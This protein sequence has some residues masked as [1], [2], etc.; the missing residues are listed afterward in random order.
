MADGELKSK[1]K[2]DG[3]QEYKKALNDAYR[4]LRVLRSELK[5]E[6][7]EL[8]RNATAQ[9]KNSKK[10]DSLK[11]QIDQQKKIV[12]TLTKAL[13]DSR[14]EYADNEEVQDK[15][16]EKLNKAREALANMENQLGSAEDSLKDLGDSMKDVGADTEQATQ[17]VVS[18]NDC[19]KSI[20]D[21]VGGV[22]NSMESIFSSTVETMT[23]MVEEM[24]SLMAQAWSAAGDWKQI[25][26]IWGGSLEDIE[27]VFMGAKLQGVDAGEITGGIQKLVTNV[28]SGNKETLAALKTLGIEEA[29]YSNHW[30]F[31]MDTMTKLTMHHGNVRFD[32]ATALFGDKKGSGMTDVVDNWNDMLD[33]YMTD[34]EGTG[35]HLY[36]D[37]I[38]ALDGVAHKI[39]ET[40]ELWNALKQNVGAKLVDILGMDTLGD[41]A[42]EILRDVAKI[43]SGQGDRKEVI[44]KLEDD[45]QKTFDDLGAALENLS[46]YMSELGT[47]L[48]QST[49]PTI[50]LIGTML[51][52][53][54]GVL[55]WVGENSDRIIAVLDKVFPALV[56]NKTLEAFTGQGIGEWLDSIFQGGLKIFEVSMLGKF[57]KGFFNGGAGS[58]ASAVSDAVNAGATGAAGGGVLGF[59]FQSIRNGAQGLLST[60]A[61]WFTQN[62]GSATGLG[63]QWAVLLDQIMHG[64]SLGRAL[65]GEGTFDE[66]L[67]DASNKA[68]EIKENAETFA[69]DWI[70]LFQTAGEAMFGDTV[71]EIEKNAET[72]ADDWNTLFQTAG[73][74]I[75]GSKKEEPQPV[76]VEEI[77]EPEEMAP[78]IFSPEQ[79]AAAQAIWD[80]W[81]AGTDTDDDWQSLLNLF[82]GDLETYNTLLSN[83]SAFMT[84]HSEEE[85]LPGDVFMLFEDFA[86][87]LEH[88]KGQSYGPKDT[89]IELKNEIAITIPVY[90]D[91]EMVTQ[92]VS[93]Q[94]AGSL[95]KILA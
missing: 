53:L 90:V 61:N 55:D 73:A 33:K 57:V 27:R 12:E 30:D 3:E 78:D 28:H 26:T 70:T 83:I 84:E 50:A 16:E 40:Q 65:T 68:E 89:P 92:T 36:D 52:K 35:L 4:T 85:D 59:L 63:G 80:K 88:F 11:K 38:E 60:G 5:A 41:D 9:D 74:A 23:A 69:D 75:F 77:E 87:A 81:R 66:V 13:E 43:W 8:G 48:S 15:W 10:V 71:K 19:L 21:V 42:L 79:I 32:L 47:D 46:G 1:L 67:T 31:F 34:V 45:L 56:A 76:I 54:A 95:M 24:Y 17:G 39:Q 91:G 58:G 93:R 25:Q 2:L 62:I 6:T 72:F 51:Q 49:N 29:N 14:K 7:A 86:D 64:T 22:A 20:G 37:E 44:F 82:E 94:V 18:L